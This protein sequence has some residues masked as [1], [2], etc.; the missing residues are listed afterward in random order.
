MRFI[1]N[2]TDALSELSD[3]LSFLSLPWDMNIFAEIFHLKWVKVSFTQPSDVEH[4]REVLEGYL[5]GSQLLY[6][7]DHDDVKDKKKK[8]IFK[9][10]KG[11]EKKGE[12]KDA[13]NEKQKGFEKSLTPQKLLLC[14]TCKNFGDFAMKY[15]SD[16]NGIIAG[17]TPCTSL[18]QDISHLSVLSRTAKKQKV[19]GEALRLAQEREDQNN[20]DQQKKDKKD[21]KDKQKD[22]KDKQKK[23]T[24]LQNNQKYDECE[25]YDPRQHVPVACL[26][27]KVGYFPSR[28][29]MVQR[30]VLWS[31]MADSANGPALLSTEIEEL[32]AILKAELWLEQVW[33]DRGNTLF[34]GDILIGIFP[35]KEINM[36]GGFSTPTVSSSSSS[37]STSSSFSSGSSTPSPSDSSSTDPTSTTRSF[38]CGAS[39]EPMLC[40]FVGAKRN[41]LLVEVGVH[42]EPVF[43]TWKQVVPMPEKW[44]EFVKNGGAEDLK[45]LVSAQ[46]AVISPDVMKRREQR[47]ER[48]G[49]AASERGERREV[50]NNDTFQ[51]PSFYEKEGAKSARA[52]RE[53]PL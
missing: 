38:L 9:F 1:T 51:H 34:F 37:S 14:Q 7:A 22:D 32:A 24:F 25:E 53:K 13:Q 11:K 20:K 18:L 43:L 26:N 40:R 3:I 5:K 50:K 46:T 48:G 29:Q 12:E 23:P 17:S 8:S 39:E 33:L 31:K 44:Q 35:E 27:L 21:D 2:V 41:G 6:D 10:G 4:L 36:F 52:E 16:P 28:E 47:S 49:A 15:K 30:M 42:S 45:R 19:F